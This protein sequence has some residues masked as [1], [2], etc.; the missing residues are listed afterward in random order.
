MSKV[1]CFV[2]KQKLLVYLKCLEFNC[3]AMWISVGITP[4]PQE[5]IGKVKNKQ[6]TNN[7]FPIKNCDTLI[8][9]IQHNT[10]K[11]A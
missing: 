7:P 8:K 3:V 1:C 6:I 2:E 10:I 5:Y 4:S 9:Y 11:I